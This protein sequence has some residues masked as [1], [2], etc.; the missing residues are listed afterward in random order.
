AAAPGRWAR[1]RRAVRGRWPGRRAAAAGAGAVTQT[2]PDVSELVERARAGQHRAVA[3]LI[4]M[5][6]SDHP[7]LPE[8]SAALAPYTGTAQVIGLTGSPGVGKSSTTTE[9]VRAYRAAGHRVGVL[10]VDPSSPFSGG[11]ILGDR[12]RM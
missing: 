6:E 8:L 2:R 5:V 11:A 12:V 1:G 10:A 7:A 3:R 9:L 4:T